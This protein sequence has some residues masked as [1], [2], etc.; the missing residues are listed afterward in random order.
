MLHKHVPTQM[1]YDMM[2]HNK[3]Y[4]SAIVCG[5]VVPL[6]DTILIPEIYIQLDM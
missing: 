3:F 4:K 2:T 6:T 1:L 5:D